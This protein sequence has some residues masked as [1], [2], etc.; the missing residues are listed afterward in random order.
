MLQTRDSFPRLLV[1]DFGASTTIEAITSTVPKSSEGLTT[2]F[3][4][5]I[6][7]V[8][9]LPPER[10]KA[11]GREVRLH[12]LGESFHGKARIEAIGKRWFD[13]EVQLDIWALGGQSH[14]HPLAVFACRGEVRR[15]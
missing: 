11:F 5:R 10:L 15:C 4:Q 8:N 3:Y 13:D 12:G 2:R 1:G 9:Y 14:F 7:T 6:G